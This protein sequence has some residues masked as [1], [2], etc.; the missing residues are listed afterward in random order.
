MK[1]PAL[2]L[3]TLLA[4]LG[5]SSLPAELEPFDGTFDYVAFD[6]DGARVLEGRLVLN[7]GED[8]SVTGSWEIDWAPGADQNTVVGP[9][10]GNGSLVGNVTDGDLFANLNPQIA[11]N[12]VFLRGTYVGNQIAGAWDYSTLAGSTVGDFTA[13]KR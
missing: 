6:S 12:N 8:G 9:Q 5:C 2:G 4:A 3:V 1:G 7:V 10:V 11:D 13:A